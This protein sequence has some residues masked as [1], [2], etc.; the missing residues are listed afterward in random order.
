M[1]AAR[2]AGRY[3]TKHEEEY[4][5]EPLPPAMT[6]R[7]MV[8]AVPATPGSANVLQRAPL[9]AGALGVVADLSRQWKAFE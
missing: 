9:C 3:T 1:A 8:H 6:A 4:C 5:P 7:W 2:L